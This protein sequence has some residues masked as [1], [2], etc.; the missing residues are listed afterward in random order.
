[1]QVLPMPSSCALAAARLGWP[2]QD[3]Q[4]V[5]VVARP[6]A[7]LNAHLFSGVRL[8]V[9]SND[10]TARPPSPRCCANVASAPAACVC[11]NTWAGPHERQLAAPPKTGR[12]PISPR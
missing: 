10:G 7:A 9:L 11:S 4:V 6:L 1:M 3:V 2:L 8:L 5:S 12:T